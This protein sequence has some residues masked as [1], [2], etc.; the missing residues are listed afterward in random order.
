LVTAEHDGETI[1]QAAERVVAYLARYVRRTAISNDR[2]IGIEND[3][4]LFWYK[5]KRDGG[6]KKVAR[7]PA[8]EFIDRFVQHVLPRGKRHVR[9]YGYLSPGKRAESLKT[10]AELFDMNAKEREA[11]VSENGD[12]PT[13]EKDELPQRICPRCEVGVLVSVQEFPRPTV[14]EIMKMTLDELRQP[15][16]P[17]M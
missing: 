11:K 7:V 14:H 12:E 9:N 5:D 8:L 4:V 16:L 15:T 2:L 10:I 1:Q 17:F 3:E 6:K 13:K